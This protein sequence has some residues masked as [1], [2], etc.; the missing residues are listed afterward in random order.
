MLISTDHIELFNAAL[1]GVL[2]QGKPSTEY[3][4]AAN[5]KYLVI[6]DGEELKCGVGH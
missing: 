1:L 2:A 6:V 3:S 5:C 4:P